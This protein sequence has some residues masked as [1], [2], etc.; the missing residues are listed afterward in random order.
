MIATLWKEEGRFSH[1]EGGATPTHRAWFLPSLRASPAVS[2]SSRK[3]DEL[4]G[5]GARTKSKHCSQ[6]SNQRKGGPIRRKTQ[7]GWDSL[8]GKV[9]TLISV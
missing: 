9:Q 8:K 4:A 3:Y 7:W 1:Q 2:D 5:A 6:N